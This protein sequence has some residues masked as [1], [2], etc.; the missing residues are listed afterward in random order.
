VNRFCCKFA[1]SANELVVSGDAACTMSPPQR[2]PNMQEEVLG[3]LLGN[4]TEP[5]PKIRL[6]RLIYVKL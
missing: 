2:E 6:F 4:V 5:T 1:G 3:D